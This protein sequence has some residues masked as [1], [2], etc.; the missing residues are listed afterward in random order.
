MRASQR[1]L[2]QLRQTSTPIQAAGQQAVHLS[3]PHRP[4]KAAKRIYSAYQYVY[5][6][7]PQSPWW[8]RFLFKRVYCRFNEF[9][10]DRLGFVAYTH[11]DALGAKCWLERQGHFLDEWR[12]QQEAVKY[13]QGFV[14]DLPL[15]EALP[16]ESF[17]PVQ[18]H[19]HSNTAMYDHVGRKTVPITQS[20]LKRL[21][22]KIR[23]TDQVVQA[24][25]V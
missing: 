8:K 3:H 10:H 7:S 11:E 24:N 17:Q 14:I 19:P 12:A 23:A 16:A 20:S 5:T 15:D 2:T 22:A 1:T 21:D 18:V 25:P 13:P 9:F 6:I 4:E